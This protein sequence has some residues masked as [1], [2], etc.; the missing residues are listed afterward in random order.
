MEPTAV[1]GV[2]A[3]AIGTSKLATAKLPGD[4]PS[5][6]AGV[7]G[8]GEGD[9]VGVGVGV[10]ETVGDGIIGSPLA[11]VKK[12]MFAVPVPVTIGLRK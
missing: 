10:G 6:A 12:L 9:G 4:M 8:L 7:V 2:T 1:R 11:P 5:K 3:G